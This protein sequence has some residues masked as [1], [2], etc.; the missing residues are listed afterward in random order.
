VPR[1]WRTRLQLARDP[2]DLAIAGAVVL[3]CAPVLPGFSRLVVLPALLLAPGYALLWLLGQATGMRSISV[4]VPASLVLA[5]C[6]SLVLDVSGIRLGPLVLGSLLGGLTALFLVGSYGRQLV[7]GPLRQPRRTPSDDRDLA[8]KELRPAA[9]DGPKIVG[10]VADSEHDEA[11][12]VAEEVDRLTDKGESTPGQDAVFHRTNAQ[13]PVFEE[14]LIR[15]G[16]PYV[17]V[18]EDRF[19]ERREV[20]DLLAYLRLIA[21]PEDEVS[22]RRVLNVPRRGIGDRTE[23]SVAALAQRD[24]TSF[25]DALTRPGDVPGLSPRAIRAV[26]AFNELLAGLRASVDAGVPVTEITE[27]VLER[28]GYVAELEASSDTQDADRIENLNELVAVARGFDTLRGQAGPPGP[29]GPGP[30][31]GSLAEFLEQV[32]LAAVARPDPGGRGPRQ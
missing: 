17:I 15:S 8:A 14:V 19:Y 24:R 4:A 21:N 7:A 31:P 28:S 27:A 29:D 1:G 2:R 3:M 16:V 5:V 13:P 26:K 20:R 10:S 25:A 22:L 23:E 18:G 30:A 11:A 9:G 32:S 12:F 6:A